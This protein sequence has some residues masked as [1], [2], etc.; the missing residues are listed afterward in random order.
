MCGKGF[1]SNVEQKKLEEILNT[2]SYNSKITEYVNIF[3]GTNNE[4]AKFS[5]SNQ[6]PGVHVPFGMNAFGTPP[7]KDYKS[8]VLPV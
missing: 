3:M 6:H 7:A 2:K 4:G 8:L 5:R 1:K